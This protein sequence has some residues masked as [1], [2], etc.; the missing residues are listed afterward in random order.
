MYGPEPR[1][2][3]IY[4]SAWIPQDS[5]SGGVFE[6]E[7]P[8][9]PAELPLVTAQGSNLHVPRKGGNASPPCRCS[10]GFLQ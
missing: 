10:C 3:L 9:V 7:S 8:I 1:I 6:E 5:D 4:C 2:V